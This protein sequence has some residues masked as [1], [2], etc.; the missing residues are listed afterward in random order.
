MGIAEQIVLPAHTASFTTEFLEEPELV[1]GHGN[2]HIDQKTGLELFGPFTIGPRDDLMI[3]QITVGLVAPRNLVPHARAWLGRIRS[4]ITNDNEDPFTR[5]AFP[6]ISSTTSVRCALAE[7]D[8]L[9]RV[10][11]DTDLAAAL[12]RDTL[13]SG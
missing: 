11:K 10:F 3:T 13:D 9:T 8:T 5:P 6:G 2:R 1:F 12:K 7:G 4:E